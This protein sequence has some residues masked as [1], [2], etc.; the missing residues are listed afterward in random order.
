[1]IVSSGVDNIFW[2]DGVLSATYLINNTPTG[3][4]KHNKTP[5]ELWHGT[6]LLVCKSLWFNSLCS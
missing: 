5:Y 6:K 2:G 4:V 3:D 1:M